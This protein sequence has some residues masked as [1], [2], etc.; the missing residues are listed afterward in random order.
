MD[1]FKLSKKIKE[2][3]KDIGFDLVAITSANKIEDFN[4]YEK[5]LELGFSAEMEYMKRNIEKRENPKLLFEGVNS[6]ICLGLNYNRKVNFK[7]FKIAKYALGDDYH[8]FLKEKAN[9]IIQFISE[10]FPISA[11]AFTDSA[12]ILER[13]LAKRSGLGW[14]GK[15]TMLINKEKGSYFLL[16]EIFLDIELEYDEPYNKNFCGNCTKCIDNCPTNAIT[17]NGINSNLCI[18]YLTIENKNEINEEFQNKTQEYIFGCDICQDVCPWNIKY[19]NESNIKETEPRNWIS[20]K[21][22][23]ELLLM[24]Q[25]EFSKIFKNS[26]VKRSKLKGLI[27]NVL[28]S[29][30][31]D[32]INDKKELIEKLLNNEDNLIRKQANITYKKL[33]VK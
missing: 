8:D 32:Q 30:K 29:L 33:L 1:K 22:I 12:P 15:N 27:R 5:W 9:L 28:V 21:S 31:K 3:A 16:G 18:S 23:D 2:Y 6:I 20:E 19:Q 14:I 13:S 11:R 10:N 25:D 4:Y 7:D 26:P 24:K 17:E